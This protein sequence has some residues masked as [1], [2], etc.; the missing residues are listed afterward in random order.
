[1][2]ASTYQDQL[3]FIYSQLPAKVPGEEEVNQLRVLQPPSS[4]KLYDLLESD[5]K[6]YSLYEE[7][8]TA[9]MKD[10]Q[11]EEVEQERRE[12]V[13]LVVGAG[14]GHLGKV[15]LD[16]GQMARRKVRVFA[17]E[18]NV[19]AVLSLQQ[20]HLESSWGDAVQIISS[21]SHWSPTSQDQADILV[22]ELFVSQT[23]P[24]QLAAT[25][26]FLKPG[27]VCIPSSLV[28]YLAPL[29]ATKLYSQVR[30]LE[31]EKQ[32]GK[33]PLAAYETLYSVNLKVDSA[34]Y[35]FRSLM[36][37]LEFLPAVLQQ[38]NVQI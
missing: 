21:L 24:E 29:Q 11:E 28:S 16:A 36:K 17:V 10:L 1:M 4:N 13:V 19:G 35:F 27:G 33:H 34:Q 18:E 31:K 5:T 25:R 32:P 20:L 3:Q 15:V 6:K 37:S 30:Q 38:G 12:V 8:L 26:K 14:R 9:A 23:L 2:E 7:A 22:S